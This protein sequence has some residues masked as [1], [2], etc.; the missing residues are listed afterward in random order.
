M[1]FNW[2]AIGNGELTN[3]TSAGHE[4]DPFFHDLLVPLLLLKFVI[5]ICIMLQAQTIGPRALLIIL[6]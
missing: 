5:G 1:R 4:Y 6:A 3:K 2:W